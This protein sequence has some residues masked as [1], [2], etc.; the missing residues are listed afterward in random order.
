METGTETT[1]A[2]AL[3]TRIDH[4]TG[5]R[6][7]IYDAAYWRGHVAE[8][9]RL[10]VSVHE[11]C[12]GRGLALS[13]FRRWAQ[14]LANDGGSGKNVRAAKSSTPGFVE[15]ALGAGAG[16]PGLASVEVS[17]GASV[18]VKVQGKAAEQVLGLVLSGVER[19]LRG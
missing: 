13:T 19:A 16:E 2:T 9:E 3:R 17:L 12:T 15:L 5:Q 8:R 11:Y 1:S 14:R 4:R 7:Y 6:I 18:R 10:G